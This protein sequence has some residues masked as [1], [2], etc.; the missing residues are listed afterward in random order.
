MH[1]AKYTCTHPDALLV[2]LNEV[3][4]GCG[5]EVDVP[6]FASIATY[7]HLLNR[8]VIRDVQEVLD[9]WPEVI[10]FMQEN[11]RVLLVAMETLLLVWRWT[12]RKNVLVIIAKTR[13]LFH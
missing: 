10:G 2:L 11:E 9:R 3:P 1:R 6:P 7:Q 5:G 8:E 12:K 13:V 4:D